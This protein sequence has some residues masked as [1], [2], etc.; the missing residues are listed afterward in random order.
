MGTELVQGPHF[1]QHVR[2]LLICQMG[3]ILIRLFQP[4]PIFEF[5]QVLR[6]I[7]LTNFA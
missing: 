7:S 2:P 1:Y 4:I 6:T 3:R 5:N